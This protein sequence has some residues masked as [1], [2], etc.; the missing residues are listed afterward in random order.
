MTTAQYGK[1]LEMAE[2]MTGLNP[3]PLNSNQ[4]YQELFG[5][6]FEQK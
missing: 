3:M 6:F 4:A 1:W 5:K 2:S